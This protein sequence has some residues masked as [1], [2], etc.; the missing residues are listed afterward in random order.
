MG[1]D[2]NPN[3]I[4]RA[5][6]RV[7]IREAAAIL[8]VHPNTVRSRVKAGTYQAEKV[9]TE[10]G[11]TWMIDRDSLT[12]NTHT[13]DPQ[14]L[15]V[16]TQQGALQEL[17]RYIVREAGL[18]SDPEAE[19]AE[20]RRDRF[21]EGGR[22]HWKAQVDFFKHMVTVSGASMVAVIA[23]VSIVDLR[24]GW[25]LIGA[26]LGASFFFFA[27]GSALFSLLRASDRLVT[28]SWGAVPSTEEAHKLLTDDFTWPRRLT[29]SLFV[30]G[31]LG[32]SIALLARTLLAART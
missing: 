20:K 6:E 15:V 18:G 11:E 16:M 5:K 27:A 30:L 22:E 28:F 17:A 3:K 25:E 14:Q 19:A 12:T 7:T 9:V 23:V 21:I 8:G 1:E 26:T 29:Y 2:R 10:R 32:L 13:S 24:A 4:E 31:F